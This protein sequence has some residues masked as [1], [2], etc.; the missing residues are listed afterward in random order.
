MKLTLR[1]RNAFTLIELLVVIAII[2]ILIGLLLPAVQKVREAAARTQCVN[3]NKQLGL[4]FHGFHGVTGWI[5]PAG[6]D[7]LGFPRWN[8]PAGVQHST[9]P[10]IL[11]YIEQDALYRLYRWDLDWRHPTNQPVVNTLVKTFVCP[12][13]PSGDRTGTGNYTP[14]GGTSA[15]W[16]SQPSDYAPQS[17]FRRALA[18]AGYADY[19]AGDNASR[20][21]NQQDDVIGG[22]G[23]Y[24]GVFDSTGTNLAPPLYAPKNNVLAFAA[25]TDGLTT[26]VFL[27]EDAGRPG[28]YIS[29]KKL[30]PT[31]PTVG[32]SGWADRG[33][34]YGIDGFTIDG[35]SSPGPC[36]MNCNN[37]DE[38]YSFHTGGSVH[39][40]GDG[41]V[42]FVRDSLS[43][44]V[45]GAMT[46]FQGGE[47]YNAD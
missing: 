15:Q 9:L 4:A 47:I 28:R 41:S 6:V 31:S 2:A 44:K 3:N 25:I 46:T 33:L 11:P 8:V 19:I 10:F 16:R 30:H 36:F 21:Y 27:T 18:D 32:S 34:N 37:G 29:G 12:S 42:K 23:P 24:R 20:P 5:P 17:G 35:L 7:T 14:P 40:F 26:T 22:G 39:L 1:T 45:M 43:T 13:T 38:H